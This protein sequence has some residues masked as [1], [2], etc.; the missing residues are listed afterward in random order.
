MV[1]DGMRGRGLENSST[2]TPTQDSRNIFQG[3]LDTREHHTM[4]KRYLGY[5]GE[6]FLSFLKA[7][8]TCHFLY[9]CFSFC[10]LFI[11]CINISGSLFYLIQC[12]LF[13]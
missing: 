6:I 1:Y 8:S 11:F 4:L 7:F 9:L 3:T 5:K 10:F 12:V 2:H 13:L